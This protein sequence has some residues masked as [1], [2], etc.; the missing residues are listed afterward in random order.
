M[1]IV[2]TIGYREF[3]PEVKGSESGQDVSHII[4]WA[5]VD[6]RRRAGLLFARGNTLCN[7]KMR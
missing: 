3:G 7:R 4:E 2:L 1:V 5:S 6:S